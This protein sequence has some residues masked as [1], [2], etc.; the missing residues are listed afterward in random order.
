[1]D[2]DSKLVR[3]A[4]VTPEGNL[5]A[6]GIARMMGQLQ[7]YL[8]T[9]AS[10]AAE[11]LISRGSNIWLSPV[12]V[13]STILSIVSNVRLD[14]V[15][16]NLASYSSTYRKLL[17]AKAA[18]FAGKPYI[19]HLHGA[20]FAK[21]WN[22]ARGLK[23][24][25]IDGLFE[26]AAGVVVLGEYWRDVVVKNVP[27]IASKVYVFPNA[28]ESIDVERVELGPDGTPTILFLGRLGA[29]KGVPQLIDALA[30][31]G[32]TRKWRAVIA[33]DG[34]VIETRKR[35]AEVELADRVDIPGW[36]DSQAVRNLL[37]S[38]DILVLP[39]FEEGLPMSVVEGMSAGL[40]IVATPVG[41]TAEIIKNRE[42]GILVDVGEVPGLAKALDELVANE[43]YRLI[44]G[45]NA[46]ETHSRV[47]EIEAYCDRLVDLWVSTSGVNPRG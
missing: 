20:D 37:L 13:I 22:G 43:G 41:S 45:K 6:G 3:V 17:I 12:Y 27:S 35:V 21:F 4:I 31:L 1:M 24:K 38:S 18:R 29:R 2:K 39:S 9:H 8:R 23:R 42:N 44:L 40:A 30:L 11:Y 25:A 47:L 34:D 15:H 10:V 19:I 32:K 14:L 26:H 46:K 7:P 28:T 16:I 36:V 33:G 5:G